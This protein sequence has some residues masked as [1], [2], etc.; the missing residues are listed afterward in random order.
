MSARSI[1]TFL[2]DR[3]QVSLIPYFAGEMSAKKGYHIWGDPWDKDSSNQLSWR[4][5]YWAENAP[6]C[7]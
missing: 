2:L 4:I 6:G 7:G 1:W 5:V 3:G